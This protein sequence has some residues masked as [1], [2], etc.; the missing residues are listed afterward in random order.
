MESR[1][2][3]RQNSTETRAQILDELM[4]EHGT[5]LRNQVRFH[6]LSTESAEE[7]L[8]DACIQ[9]MRFWEGPRGIPALQWMLVVAKRCAWAISRKE[10]RRAS[11]SEGLSFELGD[12]E[13]ER[14]LP[15]TAPDPA[16]R[17]ERSAELTEIA[18]LLEELKPDERTAL[19]L[20]GLG[21]SYAEIAERRGWTYSKVNR[22][23]A[24]GR[25][26]VRAR[27]A[28]GER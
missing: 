16:E 1:G 8:A 28:E 27:L 11:A 12:S 22:C 2:E 24:E 5:Q 26:R 4:R 13:L 19:I 6:S 23:I 3:T 17:T 7:A 21:C 20:F 10:R 9:F 14:S 25:E 18:V 15:D